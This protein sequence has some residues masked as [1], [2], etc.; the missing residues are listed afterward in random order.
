LIPVLEVIGDLG[1][2]GR[3]LF[4]PVKKV[5]IAMPVL[6]L[7]LN[8]KAPKEWISDLRPLA[9]EAL[10]HFGADAKSAIPDLVDMLKAPSELCRAAAV[11][12]LGA[13]GP[14]AND[15]IPALQAMEKEDSR[16][17]PLVQKALAAIRSKK[18]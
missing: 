15:A 2:A 17:R 9:A 3:P 1:E 16:F 6:L 8:E 18:Q 10:G 4:A 7:V 13:I 5:V 11:E 12:A 14:T